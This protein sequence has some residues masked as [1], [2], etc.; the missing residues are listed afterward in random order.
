MRGLPPSNGARLD[1]LYVHV[2]FCEQLCPYCT[3]NRYP[4]RPAAAEAY[5][6]H[7]RA[8]LEM[9]ARAGYRF[10]N[11]YVGGGTPTIAMDELRATLE[12]ARELFGPLPVSCE[13]NPNHLTDDRLRALAPYV[14][15]LSVGVQSF[16]D[17]LLRQMR[18]HDAYGSGT[19]ILRRVSAAAGRLPVLNIDLIYNLPGQSRAMLDA[20]ID[21]A[22]A[23]GADQ[24]TFYPL[25]PASRRST[26]NASAGALR[27]Q[28]SEERFYREIAARVGDQ[29][30]PTSAWCFSRRSESL[31][32]EY[33]L[34]GE[35]YVG[36]GAGAFSYLDGTL[37]AN[38][39]S[40]SAY[41]RAIRQRRHSASAAR[42]LSARDRRRY[43]FLMGLFGLR[44]DRAAF[45]VR[46]GLP[47][48]RALPVE[49]AF[50]HL[51]RA[52]ES[53]P[54]HDLTPTPRG[55]YLVVAMMREF[56][57][58]VSALRE[59]A[60]ALLSARPAPRAVAR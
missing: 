58:A 51:A 50:L 22:L 55:R 48:E 39:F 45:R 56:F 11:I 46:H 10:G 9:V 14:H 52:L 19:E 35:A 25:M 2:P 12:L 26:V 29:L 23:S 24:M 1:T 21:T 28:R 30:Q 44:L 59:E 38:A 7:L 54:A 8:E 3:F 32:D 37:Y 20:D 33:I 42:R 36:V 4:F 31:I 53:D 13:T 60:R 41:D 40:L 27:R 5:F 18:R 49:L 57:V 34:D 17:G 16:Q 6:E 43:S 15:R 47:V